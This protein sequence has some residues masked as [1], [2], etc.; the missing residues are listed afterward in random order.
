MTYVALH[1]VLK[2]GREDAYDLVHQRIPDELVEAHLRAGIRDWWIWRSGRDLFHLIEC[3]DLLA[4]FAQLED[5]PANERWQEF[6]GDYVDHL[7]RPSG[8]PTLPLVWRMDDQRSSRGQT[9]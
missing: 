8:G 3:D 1:S 5:D 4:A 2:A 6:I 7:E 9:I